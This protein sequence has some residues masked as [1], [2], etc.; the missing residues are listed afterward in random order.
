MKKKNSNRPVV[1]KTYIGFSENCIS[2]EKII[3]SPQLF[4]EYKNCL[5]KNGY[6]ITEETTDEFLKHERANTRKGGY[7]PKMPPRCKLK[8]KN[9]QG[10]N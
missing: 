6:S 8:Q 9:S 1:Q 3:N 7:L 5:V 4:Q 10:V 2:T